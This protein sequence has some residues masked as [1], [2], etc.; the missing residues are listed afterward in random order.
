MRWGLKKGFKCCRLK[1][2]GCKILFLFLYNKMIVYVKVIDLGKI[3]DV[4]EVFCL[5]FD[6]EEKVNGCFRYL[7]DFLLL[8]VFFYL[9]LE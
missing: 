9:I 5:D 3:G 8:F 7:E 1:V 6:E 2:M 4:R